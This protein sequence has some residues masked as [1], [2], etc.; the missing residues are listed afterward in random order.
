MQDGRKYYVQDRDVE[1]MKVNPWSMI[2][3]LSDPELKVLLET[4]TCPKVVEIAST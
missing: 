3:L 2:S 4:Y 1:I